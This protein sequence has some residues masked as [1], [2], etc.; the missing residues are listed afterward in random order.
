MKINRNSFTGYQYIAAALKGSEFPKDVF[1]KKKVL[2]AHKKIFER[3]DPKE[4]VPEL[5]RR[6]VINDIDTANIL[7]TENND[8]PIDATDILLDR[9]W[10]RHGNWFA[11]F[12]DVLSEYYSHICKKV[13]PGIFTSKYP[14][15]CWSVLLHVLEGFRDI[16][17]IQLNV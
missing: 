14:K 3:L 17:F 16:F 2:T 11:E 1:A 12:L 8:G 4:V 13:D 9:V 7:A 6:K 15:C 5:N 10:R